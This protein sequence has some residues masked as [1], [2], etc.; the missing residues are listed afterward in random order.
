[1]FKELINVTLITVGIVFLLT[2]FGIT[3]AVINRWKLKMYFLLMLIPLLGFPIIFRVTNSFL[4]SKYNYHILANSRDELLDNLSGKYQCP[5]IIPN[6]EKYDLYHSSYEWYYRCIIDDK[7]FEK[8]LTLGDMNNLIKTD[9]NNTINKDDIKYFKKINSNE[10]L[11][12]RKIESEINANGSRV[13]ILR[14]SISHDTC[15]YRNRF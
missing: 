3:V 11:W 8:L 7:N 13:F 14:N 4:Y 12:N 9:V 10:F 6:G 1:M 5:E 15:V 2:L